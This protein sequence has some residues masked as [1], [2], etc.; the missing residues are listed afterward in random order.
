MRNH[1][2]RTAVLGAIVLL[3][4]AVLIALAVLK[5]VVGVD[6]P[7]EAVEPAMTPIVTHPLGET[8]LILAPYLALALALVPVVR[9]VP[10]WDHG[11]LA[12]HVTVLAPALNIAVAALSIAIALFMAAYWITENL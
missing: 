5:Y 6:G 10:R 9:S 8:V 11:R 7:F 2:E 4:T 12:G 1:P 3:P